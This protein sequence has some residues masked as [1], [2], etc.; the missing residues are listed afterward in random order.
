MK[1]WE[2]IGAMIG[3]EVD[4]RCEEGCM[5][6]AALLARIESAREANDEALLHELMEELGRLKPADSF[7]YAEP[8]DLEAIRAER[9]D[10]PRRVSVDPATDTLNRIHGAWLGRAA[11]CALGKPIEKWSKQLIEDYLKFYDALPL[12]DYI[13]AGKGFPDEHPS[14][15]F[16]SGDDCTRGNITH[17][18]RDDDMD[19]T[20]LGLHTLEQRGIEFTAEEAGFTWMD[21][22]PYNLLYT[23]ERIAY[24]NLVNGL[25]PPI[26]AYKANPFREWIGAQI[27]ADIWGYVTPGWPE[28]AAELAYRDATISHVKNGVYGEMFI[29]AMLAAAFITH[30]MEEAVTIGLSEI[31][32]NCRLAEAVRD[33]MQWA[34]GHDDWQLTWS[35]INEKYGH[36]ASVHTINNAALVVMGLLHGK[37]DFEKTITTTVLGGWDTDCT[38]ATAGSIIGTMLGAKTL[39]E[40]W[41]GVFNDHMKS[42][43]RE[44][45]ECRISELASRTHKIAVG[46]LREP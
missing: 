31:P 30:D 4:Q 17:M 33:T 41:V 7:P 20:V 11:G 32:A 23:A 46:V 37:G 42:A 35:K 36:Y 26:S 15:Y 28:K 3:F 1:S 21:R 2:R 25:S 19:Y 16:V 9:P 13:P 45:Q 40:K 22:M 8:D 38:G 10:G 12:N 24:R 27:R 39:P 44:S 29:A 6:D 34:G 14:I 18:P 5:L 43:V